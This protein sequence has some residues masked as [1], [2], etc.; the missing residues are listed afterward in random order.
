VDVLKKAADSVRLPSLHADGV[1]A[2]QG[3]TLG[4]GTSSYLYQVRASIPLFTGGRIRAEKAKAE[5]ERKQIDQHMREL[6]DQIRFEIKTTLENMET[7]R[8]EVT[9]AEGA[10]Q[11][12]KEELVQAKDRYEAGVA[13]NLEVTSAQETLARANDSQ[14]AALYKYNQALADW[15][16]ATGQVEALY[17]STR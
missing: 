9:V 3:L 2:Y 15:T 11:L 12:A 16:F 17:G 7:A 8:R 5:L 1:W 13:I 4:Q 10:V 14:I 6:E